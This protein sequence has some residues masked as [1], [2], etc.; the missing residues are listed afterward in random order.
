MSLQIR[1]SDPD[2]VV[3]A[4]LS[5]RASQSSL[6]VKHRSQ[7]TDYELFSGSYGIPV[8]GQGVGIS[9]VVIEEGGDEVIRQEAVI[10]GGSG[11]VLTDDVTVGAIVIEADRHTDALGSLDEW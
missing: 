8:T 4:K 7:G 2:N 9:A 11:M 10:K 5:K 1:K 3:V 6:L